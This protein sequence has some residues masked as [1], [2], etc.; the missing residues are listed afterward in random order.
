MRSDA[1]A[2]RERLLDAA[3]SVFA[4]RGIDAPLSAIARRADVGNAT[5][6][7]NFPDRHALVMALA[8]RTWE[9]YAAVVAAAQAAESGWRAIQISV[10]GVMGMFL[11][12]PW[13]PAVR[14]YARET[15]D[16]DPAFESAGREIIE[17]AW[18]EGSLRRD[19]D[20]TDVAFIPSLLAGLL[21]LPEPAR[22]IIIARQRDIILDGLRAE[23]V[24]RRPPGGTPLDTQLFRE[25]VRP[26]EARAESARTV[27]E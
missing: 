12:Y 19:I 21:D 1:S 15:L 25:L 20:A 9:R 23:G 16:D 18:A 2:N 27:E 22:S 17:R 7:R 5:F 14:D 3:S 6:Y 10:D 24:P 11:D 4:E 26:G 13:L 8:A